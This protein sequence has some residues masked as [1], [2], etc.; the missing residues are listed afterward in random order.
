LKELARYLTDGVLALASCQ[1][2][3]VLRA[4]DQLTRRLPRTIAWKQW[5]NTSPHGP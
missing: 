3:S 1:T 4:L 2:P 5:K